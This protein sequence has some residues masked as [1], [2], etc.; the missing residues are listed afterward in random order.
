M[1]V[2]DPGSPGCHAQLPVSSTMS[3]AIRATS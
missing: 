3:L 2:L 1:L